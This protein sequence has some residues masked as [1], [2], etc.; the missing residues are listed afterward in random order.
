MK[1]LT[2]LLLAMFVVLELPISICLSAGDGEYFS[3][4][5]KESRR[6]FNQSPTSLLDEVKHEANQNA[7]G[8]KVQVTQLDNV[9]SSESELDVDRR[10]TLTR[11]LS[12]IKDHIHDYLQYAMYF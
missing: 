7:D 10:F 2:Y 9:N 5:D 3:E 1:K 8:D 4:G 12:Y 6:T 11:T